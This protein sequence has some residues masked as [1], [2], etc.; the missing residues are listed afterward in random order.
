MEGP[1]SQVMDAIKACHEAVHAM[2]TP[3]IAVSLPDVLSI[4][5]KP[6]SPLDRPTSESE[7]GLTSKSPREE[8]LAKYLEW[9]RFSKR[10]RND[11]CTL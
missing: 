3:R 10:I 4:A 8:M 2:G 9:K 6:G 7:R 11:R 5:A 1:W